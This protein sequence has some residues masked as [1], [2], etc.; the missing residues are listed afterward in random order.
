MGFDFKSKSEADVVAELAS[1][2]SSIVQ[3][4]NSGQIAGMIILTQS[5]Y[6]ALINVDS[7]NI[8]Y[9]VTEEPEV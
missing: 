5:E 2:T 6:D 1:N 8:L 9:F 4:T 7:D 3:L